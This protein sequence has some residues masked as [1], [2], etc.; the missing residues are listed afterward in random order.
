MPKW[1]LTVK[2]IIYLFT[3]IVKYIIFILLFLHNWTRFRVMLWMV[4][5]WQVC[6][7][8]SK[9]T[10]N[11][12]TEHDWIKK[13]LEGKYIRRYVKCRKWVN[14]NWNVVFCLAVCLQVLELDANVK[15]KRSNNPAKTSKW[16]QLTAEY[17]GTPL[18]CRLLLVP[19]IEESRLGWGLN[20]LRYWQ[21]SQPLFL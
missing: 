16:L 7:I 2:I 12:N 18:E 10:N 14:W 17:S 4:N 3:D 5:K 6:T 15:D 13:L 8:F 20:S 9:I 1:P 11:N 21:H 19:V